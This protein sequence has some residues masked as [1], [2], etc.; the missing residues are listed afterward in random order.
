MVT[1]G[2]VQV[3]PSFPG[4]LPEYLVYQQLTKKGIEF[5]YQASE[6]GGRQERGGAILDFYIPSLNRGLNIQSTYYHYG[7][8]NARLAD[9]LQREQLE[10]MGIQIVYIDEEDIYRNAAYF[11]EQALQGIDHSLASQGVM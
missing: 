8:P 1:E 4:T 9:R 7:R 2:M 5:E 6:M 3:P 11:V 10:A